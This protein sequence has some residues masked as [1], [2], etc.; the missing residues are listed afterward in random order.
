MR[1]SQRFASLLVA[2]LLLG[3]AIHQP[4]SAGFFGP[5]NTPLKGDALAAKLASQPL[6]FSTNA[7]LLEIRTKGAA[8]GS[9]LLGFVV[10]SAMAS[11]G[12]GMPGNAQ[13]MQRSMQANADI[14]RSFNQNLQVALTQVAA[15]QAE[16]PKG[17]IAR[18]GPI[19]VVGQQLIASI[20]QQPGLTLA[21]ASADAPEKAAGLQIQVTQ[22]VWKLDFSMASS[23]YTLLYET[24]AALYEKQSDTIFFKSTCKGEFPKKMEL[25]AW[26]RDDFSEVAQAADAIGRQCATSLVAA[27]G[28]SQVANVPAAVAAG[29]TA[30]AAG[31]DAAAAPTEAAVIKDAALATASAGAP[32]AAPATSVEGAS[33]PTQSA[34]SPEPV[35]GEQK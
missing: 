35:I 2:V 26:E 22:P 7:A 6:A 15:T 11:G 24:A 14:A 18:E 21:V 20:K 8:V 5:T 32:A 33:V 28:L 27:L 23:S 34:T 29:V 19:V 4:A 1:P 16:K 9:F 31:T 30:A 12:G 17:Q 13:Q 10:S 25:E 3:G